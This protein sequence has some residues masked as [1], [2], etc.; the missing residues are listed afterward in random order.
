M[1]L[2]AKHVAVGVD[3]SPTG[4]IAVREAAAL[5]KQSGARLSLVTVVNIPTS[6]LEL[7]G[8]G[9][10]M[11]DEVVTD[12]SKADQ[13]EAEAACHEAGVEFKSYAIHQHRGTPGR[14]MAQF[15]RENGVDL[16]LVGA[17]GRGLPIGLYLGSVARWVA[18]HAP[19][20]V[21]VIRAPEDSELAR[22]RDKKEK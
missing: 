1:L 6:A 7:V 10:E 3:G 21:V 9:R 22:Q 17:H 14:S 20:S 18:E 13:Q 8:A 16:M 5:V 11:I 12:L 4:L 2:D 15:A 19:C